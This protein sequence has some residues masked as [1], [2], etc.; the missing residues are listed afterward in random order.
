MVQD[1]TINF[2]DLIFGIISEIMV[3]LYLPKKAIILLG[4]EVTS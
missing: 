3:I 2:R 4:K 1:G